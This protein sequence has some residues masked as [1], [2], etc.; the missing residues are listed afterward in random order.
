MDLSI[1]L[2][3][4]SFFFF[5]ADYYD[6]FLHQNSAYFLPHAQTVRLADDL[7]LVF[8]QYF[9]VYMNHIVT[10]NFIS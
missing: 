5:K 9:L 10:R 2:L 4:S 7:E 3:P 1:G 6:V 8:P